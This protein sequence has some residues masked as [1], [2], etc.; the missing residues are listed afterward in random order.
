[1][2]LLFPHKANW[3]SSAVLGARHSP[4]YISTEGDGPNR[5]IKLH[6]DGGSSGRPLSRSAANLPRT[7]LSATNAAESPTALLARKEMQ[8][9]RLLQ[10]EPSSLRRPDE[11]KAPIRLR[12]EER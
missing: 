8:S 4:F 9:W 1:K 11:F 10:L 7:V 12:S 3:R 2:Q 5:T 6:Q